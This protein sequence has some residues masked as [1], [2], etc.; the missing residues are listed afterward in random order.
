ML[1]GLCL[2]GAAVMRLHGAAAVVWGCR[3]AVVWDVWGAVMVVWGR[4][5][6]R[7]YGCVGLPLWLCE[8]AVMRLCGAAIMVVWGC[9][10]YRNNHT[11]AGVPWAFQIDHLKTWSMSRTSKYVGSRDPVLVACAWHPVTLV[12]CWH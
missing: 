2:Y 4:S 7:H 3:Y 10:Y 1:S 9:S 8:A 11:G 5:Y 6:Y 12:Q